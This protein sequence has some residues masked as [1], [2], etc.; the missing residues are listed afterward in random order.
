METS[1]TSATATRSLVTAL[2]A[3]SG[4]DM[5]ALAND[6]ATAQFAA[7]AD[8][9]TAKSETLERRISAA[10]DLKSMLLSLSTSLGD[11]I[12]V[13]DLSP[14]PQVANASVASASLSG[15]RQPSGTY[16][17]EVTALASA[18]T[19]ASPAF[20]A[21]DS[22]AGSGTLTFRFGSTQGGT[23]AE[24]TAHA[25]LSVEIATGSTLGDVA[26]AINGKNAGLTAYVAQTVDGAQLVVKG[27][28]GVQNGFVMEAAEDPA[29]PGLSALA[30][31]PGSTSGVLL[32]SAADAE[33]K[34]DG[35]SMTASDNTVS[36]AVPGV[37]LKLAG[38]NPGVPTT[39]SFADPTAS[40]TGAMQELTAAL[41][42]I[43]AVLN[44]ATDPQTGDLA[45]DPGARALR[46]KFSELAG[47]V[48]MPAATGGAPRT[49][50]DLGISTQRDGT[51]A[52][53]AKRLADALSRDPEGVSAMFTT[54]LYGVYAT[55]DGIS[56]KASS[57]TDPGALGGSISKYTKELREVGEDQADLVEKQEDLRASL[58]KRFAVSE[59]RIGTAKSTLSFLES[60][61][62]V[63]NAQGSN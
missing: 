8:R 15:V 57:L 26:A 37:T 32:K 59:V 14:Q 62:A 13:G 51:F 23:F 56:R 3:G 22:P 42:E 6:L 48:M 60:Q 36:D 18:Q 43:A 2:G 28:E 27:Q 49:L 50:A 12:R 44:E 31:S 61:I 53:D 24:D 33:F 58:A 11:R 38:A 35:L 46:R 21:A 39:L 10:S 29:E 4:I 30:W 52:L 55:I 63:W 19:L 45:R 5:M 40:I 9:L 25:P 41:N 7:R 1:S 47:T 17:L 34:I 20:A 54:G 16:S